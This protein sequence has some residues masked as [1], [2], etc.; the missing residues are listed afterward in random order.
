MWEKVR[1]FLSGNVFF[2]WGNCRKEL[3]FTGDFVL[4]AVVFQDSLILYYSLLIFHS[5]TALPFSPES[6]RGII[7]ILR[8]HLREEGL[9]PT[10]AIGSNFH[11]IQQELSKPLLG[12]PR[13][14]HSATGAAPA[15]PAPG[16]AG[17][18]PWKMGAEGSIPHVAANFPFI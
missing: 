12:K 4:Y 3:Q 1:T 13:G 18:S 5:V 16:S 15:C 10:I 11:L 14:S 8:P 9:I 2:K 6:F 17:D 7:F